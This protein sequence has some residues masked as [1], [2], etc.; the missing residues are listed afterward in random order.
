MEHLMLDEALRVTQRVC[1]E[2]RS[3]QRSWVHF[4]A[5]NGETEQARERLRSAVDHLSLGG[6]ITE[7]QKAV[8]RDTL[9]ALFRATD[10]PGTDCLTLCRLSALLK[11][12]ELRENR[13]EAA[14]KW[15]SSSFP[16]L[17]EI[18]P[19]HCSSWM[20]AVVDA[21]PPKWSDTPPVD[22][23]LFD[24]RTELKDLRDGT[25]AHAIERSDGNLVVNDIRSFITIASELAQHAELTFLESRTDWTADWRRLMKQANEFW[26]RCQDGF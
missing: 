2:V 4:E 22:R 10:N 1:A 15:S 17:R 16:E 19:S 12:D 26:D 6:T 20:Q 7:L 3:A 25:L 5:I 18:D 23:R 24:L 8:V 11:S 9:M 21:V 14:K 13:C